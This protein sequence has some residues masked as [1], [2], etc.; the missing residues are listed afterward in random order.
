MNE[1][2]HTWEEL[3]A[4]V[5]AEQYALPDEVPTDPDS[6]EQLAEDLESLCGF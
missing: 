5:E 3:E 4:I 6:F 1:D 2:A